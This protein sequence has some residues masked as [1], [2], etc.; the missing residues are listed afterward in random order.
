MRISLPFR[1][2]VHDIADL[3]LSDV[4]SVFNLVALLGSATLT[5]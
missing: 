2:A 3:H 4:L 5:L 1:I